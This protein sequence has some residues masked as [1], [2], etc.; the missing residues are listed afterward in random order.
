MTTSAAPAGV[1]GLAVTSV[2]IRI[3]VSGAVVS[4]LRLG[5]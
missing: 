2:R 5:S 4:M 3:P 1:A